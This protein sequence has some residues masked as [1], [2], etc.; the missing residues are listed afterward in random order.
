MSSDDDDE[1]FAVQL[2]GS[3][4][5]PRTQKVIRSSSIPLRLDVGA[6]LHSDQ[7]ILRQRFPMRRYNLERDGRLTNLTK[8]IE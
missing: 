4:M 7:T 3:G 1:C 6:D 2:D 5:Y 8:A